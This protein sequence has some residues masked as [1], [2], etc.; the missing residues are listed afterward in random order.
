M[1]SRWITGSMFL[2]KRG[3]VFEKWYKIWIMLS[4]GQGYYCT[5]ISLTLVLF[6]ESIT[7]MFD[8]W[9]FLLAST[10]IIYS[11]VLFFFLTC[12]IGFAPKYNTFIVLDKNVIL[13]C[14]LGCFAF[15]PHNHNTA[16]EGGKPFLLSMSKAKHYY[17]MW[18]L[19]WYQSIS[20]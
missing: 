16:L 18:L 14:Q 10:I 13:V 15:A 1:L 9:S 11:L 3:P 20:L 7:D 6:A 2:L 4:H 12:F 17:Q 5:N 8:I 19:L